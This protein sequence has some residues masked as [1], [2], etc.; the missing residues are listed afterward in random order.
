MLRVTLGGSGLDGFPPDQ[1]SAYIKL[2]LTEP[3]ADSDDKPLI[4]TY[5][6]RRFNSKTRE[7]DVDFV[8]HDIDG[9]AADWAKRCE[10]GDTIRFMGPGPKKLVNDEAD[11]H[12]L[13][14][15]MSALPA[16]SAN[17]E[18]MQATA[19]GY[20]VLEIIDEH[21]RQEINAPEGLDIHW[22][23]NP[24]PGA[25]N[26]ILFDAVQSL[27]WLDGTPSAWVAGEFA[28]SIAIRKYLI[29]ERGLKRDRLYASSYWQIGQTE[30]GHRESKAAVKS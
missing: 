28:Q 13:A 11:W 29:E 4:R 8:L 9:P 15:D 17:I 1:D 3:P 23:V 25:A 10:P 21:D 26:T 2:R 7:L 14:G 24:N 5:T 12:L 22:V 16:I 20:A 18:Y 19:R 27:E 6:V 30:D